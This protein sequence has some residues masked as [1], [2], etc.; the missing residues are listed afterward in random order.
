MPK[1]KQY[2]EV[3][4]NDGGTRRVEGERVFLVLGSRAAMPNVTGV[5]EAN[6]M[7]HIE[8]LDL[9]RLPPHLIVIGGGYVGLELA[10]AMRRFGS[11]VTLIEQARSSRAAKIPTWAPR[12][13]NYFTTKES[14]CCSQPR[15][16]GSKGVPAINFGSMPGAKMANALSKAPI[17]LSLRAG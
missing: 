12:S 5:A 13:S 2:D 16:R 6:P 8:A 1:L 9:D 14:T 3:V 4:L 7:T 11:Q 10:Q 17:F 15:S